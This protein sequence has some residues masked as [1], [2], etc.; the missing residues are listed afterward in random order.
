VR[1][2]TTVS[3]V[4]LDRDGLP[5][6]ALSA[7][8]FEAQ[9]TA[10]KVAALGADLR[11][12][13]ASVSGTLSGGPI[14]GTAPER[15][16]FELQGDEMALDFS[17]SAEH[18]AVR[19][20][21]RRFAQEKMAPLVNEAEENEVFPRELFRQWGELGL[22]GVRYPQADGGSGMDK[23]ADC[24]IREEMSVV[25]QAFASSWSAHTHLGIWPIWRA[26][27][28]EQKERFFRPR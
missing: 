26:G 25:C 6:M 16:L 9:L 11:E 21:V 7:V 10:T 5:F 15:L 14:A 22:L 4:V 1:G 24:I 17:F 2:A 20:M 12:R 18:E 19:D 27:T 8:G 3:A 23:V 13:A 28:P